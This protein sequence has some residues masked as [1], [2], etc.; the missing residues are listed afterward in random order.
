MLGCDDHTLILGCSGLWIPSRQRKHIAYSLEIFRHGRSC[1]RQRQRWGDEHAK[2]SRQEGC[3]DH[4]YRGHSQGRRVVP[5]RSVPLAGQPITC[6]SRWTCC[7]IRSNTWTQLAPLFPVSR[8]QGDMDVV[9]RSAFIRLAGRSGTLVGVC[10]CFRVVANG[11][12]GGHRRSSALTGDCL[13]QRQWTS[14]NRRLLRASGA[15]SCAP[16][17]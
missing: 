9:C 17:F 2:S 3:R 12:F 14:R 11:F 1:P 5:G 6:G 4:H 7:W 13:A 10:R 15:C 16:P 8:R